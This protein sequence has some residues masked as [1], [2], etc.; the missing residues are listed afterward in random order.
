MLSKKI[1]FKGIIEEREKTDQ[2][3][4]NKEI[5]PEEAH[6]LKKVHTSKEI[7]LSYTSTR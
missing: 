6:T 3:T 7:S 1:F 4:I 5:A 2:F